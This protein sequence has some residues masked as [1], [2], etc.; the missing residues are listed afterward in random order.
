MAQWMVSLT[1]DNGPFVGGDRR[2]SAVAVDHPIELVPTHIALA[3]PLRVLGVES[4]D[5][6]G[7][8]VR[9]VVDLGEVR[10]RAL[11]GFEHHVVPVLA[12]DLAYLALV[13]LPERKQI[14]RTRTR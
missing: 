12:G 14:S 4:P 1:F 2:S 11:G 6:R 9:P 8:G 10:S 13:E 3:E 7:H 5:D